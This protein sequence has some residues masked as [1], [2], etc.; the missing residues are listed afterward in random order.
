MTDTK[1]VG[2]GKVHRFP[3][4]DFKMLITVTREAMETLG[5]MTKLYRQ[6]QIRIGMSLMVLHKLTKHGEWQKFYRRTFADSHVSLRQAQRY[7]ARA[8]D[9]QKRPKTF[10]IG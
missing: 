9:A 4:Y 10:L 6:Q 8:R 2:A 7:M 3:R 1:Y 5:T